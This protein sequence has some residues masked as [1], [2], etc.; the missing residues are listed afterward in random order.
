MLGQ[1][2]SMLI[3]EVDRLQAHRQAAGGRDRDRPRAHRHADAAQEGRG[4]QVRRVLRPRP[5]RHDGRRPRHHRQHGARIRRDLR[6]LP[7]RRRDDRLSHDHEPHRRARR[8][9]RGLR[10]GAGH[11]AHRRDARSGLHR[12]ARTRSRRRAA[13]AGRPEAPAGPRDARHVEGASSS[14]PWRRSSA[15]PPSSASASRSMAPISTSATA[16]WSSPRSPPAP[17]PRTRA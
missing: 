16:T 7:D 8:P 15:R 10:Q 4:R 6:L 13:L 11:V 3:P 9:R 14:A 1:P 17:T 5:Q 12:H 2:I